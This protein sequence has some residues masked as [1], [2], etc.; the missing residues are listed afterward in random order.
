MFCFELN[1]LTWVKVEEKAT[2]K[3]AAAQRKAPA[4]MT[5]ARLWRTAR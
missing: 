5:W 1:L 2:R 3:V 4:A